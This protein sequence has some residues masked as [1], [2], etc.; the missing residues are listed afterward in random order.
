MN[1][2]S[3]PRWHDLQRRLAETFG[4]EENSNPPIGAK[5][6]HSRQAPTSGLSWLVRAR[7]GAVQVSPPSR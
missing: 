5:S 4:T 1:Q 7:S 2:S 3:T 6:L